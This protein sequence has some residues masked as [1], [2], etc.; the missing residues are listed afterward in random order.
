MDDG[1]MS[2]DADKSTERSAPRPAAEPTPPDETILLVDLA[3]RR[4]VRGGGGTLLFG[5]QPPDERD[6]AHER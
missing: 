1:R 3:P 4:D 6:R 5:Q 2:D